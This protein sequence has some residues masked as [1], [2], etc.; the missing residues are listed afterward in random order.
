[1]RDNFTLE[2]IECDDEFSFA[3]F[4]GPIAGTNSGANNP[5]PMADV[6]SES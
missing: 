2:I 5:Y 3:F 4:T 1:M 6:S